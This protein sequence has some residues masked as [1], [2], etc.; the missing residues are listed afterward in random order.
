MSSTTK[1]TAQHRIAMWSGPRNISTAMMRSFGSREDC[2]VVDEPLYGHYLL[3]HGLDHP[4]REM[5]MSVHETDANK[6]IEWLT[7]DTPE[8][9]TIFYQ[10]QMAHHLVDD[11][12]RNWLDQVTNCFLIR[13]P[14]EMLLSLTKRLPEATLLDT[15]LP[16]Q[17]E[18]FA[19]VSANRDTPPPV[20]DARDVLLAPE[21]MLRKLCDAL[22]IPFSDNMLRWPAG[23]RSTDGAW[24][25][26]WYDAVEKS[27]EFQQY[28]PK[29]E[30][31]P[32]NLRG[33]LE[34]C[35]GY[36]EE[37]YQHRIVAS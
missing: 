13:D 3:E 6:A 10:K 11:V 34:K 19:R 30:R 17:I 31:L 26:Y 5:V 23:K 28:R 15:G 33:L 4:G 1:T 9:K 18:I 35:T 7:G 22:A 29:D 8:G 24:A 25:P 37:L 20:I 14:E 16:Q 36:Y 12:P 2:F 27:T 32:E 21:A